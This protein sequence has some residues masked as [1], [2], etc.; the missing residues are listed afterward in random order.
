MTSPTTRRVSAAAPA[1]AGNAWQARGASGATSSLAR[2]AAVALLVTAYS[3]LLG[4]V[5]GLVWPRL[6]PHV[7]LIRAINGSE[8]AAKAVLGDDMWFAL[9]G[10][11]AGVVSVAILL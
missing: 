6:A 10:L 4:A 7:Q 9:L 5:L 11:V 3:T 8:S 1:T 2:E